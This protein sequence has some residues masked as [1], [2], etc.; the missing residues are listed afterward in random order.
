[1]VTEKNNETDVMYTQH[2]DKRKQGRLISVSGTKAL[3]Y[4]EGDK[5]VGYTTLDEINQMAYTRKLQNYQLDY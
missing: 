4:F 5:I 1:M 3:G 2:G